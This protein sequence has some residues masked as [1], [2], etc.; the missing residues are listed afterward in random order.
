MRIKLR[1]KGQQVVVPTPPKELFLNGDPQPVSNHM[2]YYGG[3][4][5]GTVSF[6]PSPVNIGAYIPPRPQPIWTVIPSSIVPTPFTGQQ[7]FRRGR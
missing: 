4:P 5:V 6:G 1:A 2:R 3:S 7:P